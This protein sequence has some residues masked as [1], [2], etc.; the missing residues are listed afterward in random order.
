MGSWA[1]RIVAG[2]LVAVI[3]AVAVYVFAIRRESPRPGHVVRIGCAEC[4][5]FSTETSGS[6]IDRF[7]VEVVATAARRIKQ[8]V[9]FF[10]IPNRARASVRAKEIDVWPRL[11]PEP[12]DDGEIFF[13]A[14]WVSMN[15]SLLSRRG[16]QLR[17]GAKIS[18]GPGS[19]ERRIALQSAPGAELVARVGD[20]PL[21]QVCTG[22]IDAAL[23]DSRV[24]SALLLTD[25]EA[26]CQGVQF[27]SMPSLEEA[28]PASVAAQP[29]SAWAAK[30]LRDEISR[31]AA[32][33]SLA[34][35]HSKWFLVTSNDTR[36][37]DQLRTFE[38]DLMSVRLSALGFAALMLLTLLQAWKLRKLSA[39]AEGAS[40]LK[41]RFVANV[42]HELRTPL[43]GI[44]GLVDMLSETRMT[45]H[46][47]EL[48]RLVRNTAGSLVQVIT[49]LLD[50]AKMEAGHREVAKES[51]ELR[52]A[53]EEVCAVM[54]GRAAEKGIRLE[55]R[56]AAGSDSRLRAEAR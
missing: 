37:F 32:D 56:G 22:A 23:V 12:Q 8:P 30:L 19:T 29:G 42:S 31:M 55:T 47:T 3:A 49:D 43:S 35:L 15:Y 14:P 40:L 18:V 1:Q 41:T 9:E 20:K 21:E 51:F 50:V 25:R 34:S 26:S 28:V 39:R 33:G 44:I 13:S 52:T 48:L 38:R 17:A 36:A 10:K 16:W 54:A 6:A 24:I 45:A 11:T 4:P 27:Q 53:V 46:Q 5:P 2:V 7:S